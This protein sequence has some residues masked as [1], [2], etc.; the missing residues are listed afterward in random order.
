MAK[1]MGGKIQ[2]FMGHVVLM[3][4]FGITSLLRA[5]RITRP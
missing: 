2:Q 1:A 5:R 4:Y 3:L